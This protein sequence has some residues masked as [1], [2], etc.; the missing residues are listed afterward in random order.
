MAGNLDLKILVGIK[1]DVGRDLKKMESSVIRTVGAITAALAAIKIVLFPISQAATFERAMADVAKTTGF[2]DTQIA[3][4]SDSLADMSKV[5]GTSATDLANVA[6][7]AGQLGLGSQGREAIEAFTISVARAS[8]TLGLS[9]EKTAEGGAQLSA[10]FG[11]S[12]SE[13]ERVFATI[14]EL[15]NN[16]VA[17]GGDLIDIMK[18]VGTTSGATFQEVAALAATVRQLGVPNEQAGTGLVKYLGNLLAE[19]KKFAAAMGMTQNDWVD[20]VKDNSVDAL[21]YV[22]TKLSKMGAGQQSALIKSLFG[23]GRL[24]ALGDKLVGDA[25]NGFKTLNKMLGLS[26]TGYDEGTSSIKEYNRIMDTTV[27]QVDVLKESFASLAIKAG[28]RALPA[29]QRAVERLSASLQDGE[30]VTYFENLGTSLG[31]FIDQ[32][33]EIARGINDWV[34]A[35]ENVLA[36]LKVFVAYQILAIFVGWALKLTVIVGLFRAFTAQVAVANT[37]MTAL[38]ATTAAVAAA[39]R[40]AGASI[41]TAN[42]VAAASAAGAAVSMGKLA[43]FVG[44]VGI[45]FRGLFGPAGFLLLLGVQ[46]VASWKDEILGFLGWSDSEQ[47]K[48]ERK[49]EE[50]RKKSK[51]ATDKAIAEALE[52]ADSI[53]A[54][55][56]GKPLSLEARVQLDTEDFNASLKTVL[57]KGT[58]I[59]ASAGKSATGY[60]KALGELNKRTKEVSDNYTKLLELNKQL[61]VETAGRAGRGRSKAGTT[62]YDKDKIAE[63]TKEIALQTLAWENSK[64]ALDTMATQTTKIVQA[65]QKATDYSSVKLEKAFQGIFTQ[66]D[67]QSLK[68]LQ[69]YQ[70]AIELITKLQSELGKLNNIKDGITDTKS[71]KFLEADSDVKA[72]EKQIEDVKAL[73]KKYGDAKVEYLKVLTKDSE[74]DRF[75]SLENLDLKGMTNLIALMEKSDLGTK[76]STL[77]YL[78]DNKEAITY[79]YIVQGKVVEGYKRMSDAASDYAKRAASRLN[80][81]GNEIAAL[82]IRIAK[83]GRELNTSLV[84]RRV[85]LSLDIS[86]E[87]ID[88]DLE[89][90]TKEVNAYYDNLEKERKAGDDYYLDA[91]DLE[92]DR[93]RELNAL[94]KEAGQDKSTAR[95]TS[96]RERF[97]NALKLSVDLMEKSKQAAKEGNLEKSISLS[98]SAKKSVEDASNLINDMKGLRTTDAFGKLSFEVDDTSILGMYKDVAD[99]ATPL[100]EGMRS[101][102]LSLNEASI[103]QAKKFT[104]LY[105]SAKDSFAGTDNQMKALIKEGI[106]KTEDLKKITKEFSDSANGMSKVMSDFSTASLQPFASLTDFDFDAFQK[107]L[108]GTIASSYE[109]AFVI[110]E[111]SKGKSSAEASA[112]RMNEEFNNKVKGGEVQV[113]VEYDTEKADRELEEKRIVLKNV[114]LIVD[115]KDIQVIG[116]SPSLRS[117]PAFGLKAGGPVSGPGTGTSDSI[118]TWLSNGEWVMDAVTTRFFGG[119]FFA[120]LQSMAQ[121]GGGRRIKAGMPALA[122]GGPGAN[123][124]SVGS[125][126]INAGGSTYTLYGEH[127]QAKELVDTFKRMRRS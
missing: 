65:G 124:S 64:T 106:L 41:A 16:S 120:G 63:V 15:S 23:S 53:D 70:G 20:K 21:K 9:V 37:R 8:E 60:T 7:I 52:A 6:A 118:P 68:L 24:F 105:T 74:K 5:L 100:E 93:R 85:Q 117:T 111:R 123:S 98:N 114:G 59:E 121:G 48:R 91:A 62:I 17:A 44:K 110:A 29:V 47:L 32:V 73:A 30:V 108:T 86:V 31:S 55:V 58:E 57:E 46:I 25:E 97:N 36:G 34:G 101:A 102:A 2:T 3:A 56:A 18:R 11:K 42:T 84:D 1:S 83:F 49:A 72:Q 45:A 19:S 113:R 90:A 81:V 78:E 75:K 116:G 104:D 89:A 28:T 54:A 79:Q 127:R 38:A 95:A 12:V 107:Q 33:A 35:W 88:K 67:L 126:D 13:V 99:L 76:P 14:N 87:G 92:A 40:T 4:L 10:I 109:E 119:S 27:K 80:N 103:E 51:A 26:T 71:Y 77:K 69:Q 43:G 96:L 22:L 125:I 82:R 122:G 66:Q 94:Q 115:S 50:A 39:S 112:I 61:E